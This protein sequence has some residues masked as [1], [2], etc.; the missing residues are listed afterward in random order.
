MGSSPVAVKFIMFDIENFYRSIKEG[1]LIEAL[2]FARQHMT[3]KS[4][5]RET[6]FHARKSLLYREGEPWTKKQ[7]NNFDVTMGSYDGAGVCEL[8]RI[9]M[10]SLIGNKYNPNNIGLYRDDG[11]AV[12]KNTWDPQSEKIKKTFQKIFKNKG[13][14]TIINCNIKIFNYLGVTLNLNDG[15]Y[16]PYKKHNDETNYIH[17]NSNHPPSI[18]K[19]LSMSIK[20]RLSSLSSSKE[21][22]EQTAPHYEPRIQRNAEL[23]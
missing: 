11:L 18:S 6:I 23:A 9:F 12:F 21:I 22:F 20:K 7:S 4:K 16:H 3:I 8:I 10:L 5:D 1:L 17:V 13:L 19:Q 15:S 14:D 2:E